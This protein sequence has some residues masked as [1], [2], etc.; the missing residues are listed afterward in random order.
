MA[1]A[2][3]IEVLS[4]EQPDCD[5]CG[6]KAHC[7]PNAEVR[8]IPRNIGED[9]QDQAR[10]IAG[11]PRIKT[12]E[13]NKWFFPATSLSLDDFRGGEERTCRSWAMK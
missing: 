5:G 7:R 8:K 11:G 13:N 3:G 12:P 6:L 4:R 2:T 1:G 10:R 9:A